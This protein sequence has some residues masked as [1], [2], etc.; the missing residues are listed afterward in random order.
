[1]SKKNRAGV[2][3]ST[4]PNYQYEGDEQP[5]AETL[6]PQ[7]QQLKVWLDRKGG[8][9]VVTAVRGFVGTDEALTELGKA[10]KTACGTGGTAKDGEIL[11]QGDHR[12]KIL[13]YLTGKRY[14]AKKA[15][16]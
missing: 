9:K 12:D 8:G 14:S 5:E 11:I 13:T 7:Q 6:P 16:G 4:D 2:V 1:M 10:L 3:Y 15:G